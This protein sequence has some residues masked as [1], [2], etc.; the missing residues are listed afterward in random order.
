LDTLYVAS[1]LDSYIRVDSPLL[2]G[3]YVI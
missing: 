3:L 2:V 1:I